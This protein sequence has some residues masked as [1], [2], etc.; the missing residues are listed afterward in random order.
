MLTK[1]DAKL[2][3]L[4]FYRIQNLLN[5]LAGDVYQSTFIKKFSVLKSIQQDLDE[6]VRRMLLIFFPDQNN[7]ITRSLV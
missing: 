5:Q 3:T 2:K 6:T 7:S 1:K 4:D